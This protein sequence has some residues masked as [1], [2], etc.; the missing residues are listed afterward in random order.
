M[1]DQNKENRSRYLGKLRTEARRRKVRNMLVSWRWLIIFQRRVRGFHQVSECTKHLK[2]RGHRP[3]GFTV[4]EM[5]PEARVF[6]ITSPTKQISL[7]YHLNKFSQFNYYISDV[8]CP[9]SSKNARNQLQHVL[10]L[11][12]SLNVS[13]KYNTIYNALLIHKLKV[14]K[15]FIH[16]FWFGSLT[17]TIIFRLMLR[18]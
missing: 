1:Q 7:N 4:F 5:K 15:Y 9:W 17:L 13:N 8:K 11:L 18:Y 10:T 14:A 6:E 16:R 2:P 12:A 3:N